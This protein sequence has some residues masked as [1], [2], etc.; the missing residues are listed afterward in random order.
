MKLKTIMVLALMVVI[1]MSFSM[2]Q[3]RGEEF[4]GPTLTATDTIAGRYTDPSSFLTVEFPDGWTGID[5]LGSPLVSPDGVLED[6]G[7]AGWPEVSMMAVV[8][9]RSGLEGMI[10]DAA[11][12]ES[13]YGCKTLSTR[14]VTMQGVNAIENV[15]EC[16]S[17]GNYAKSKVYIMPTQSQIAV[18]AYSVTSAEK[19]EDYLPAFEQS[20]QTARLDGKPVQVG[21]FVSRSLGLERTTYPITVAGNPVEIALESSSDISDFSFDEESKTISFT[22]AGSEDKKGVT[23]VPASWALEGPYTVMVDGRPAQDVV[24]ISDTTSQDEQTIVRLDYSHSVHEI[25]ITGAAVAPEFPPFVAGLAA[26]GAIGAGLAARKV[27]RIT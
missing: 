16:A 6:G 17:D 13:D 25:S 1:F 18:L 23:I 9:K 19:Y 24:V 5:Y 3:A 26:A 7:M 12:D 22:V 14:Y 20:V 8:M 21:S 10:S 2:L 27:L 4:Q 11:D 15:K